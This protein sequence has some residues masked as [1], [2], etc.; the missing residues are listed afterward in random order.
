MIVVAEEHVK[1]TMVHGAA[2]LQRYSWTRR[3]DSVSSTASGSA[4]ALDQSRSH[5]TFAVA[6][7]KKSRHCGLIGLLMRLRASPSLQRAYPS[8]PPGT[9]HISPYPA[10]PT[11]IHPPFPRS[12]PS[13]KPKPI[14]SYSHENAAVTLQ[15]LQRSIECWDLPQG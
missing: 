12:P 4:S 6:Y 15:S 8:L 11:S 14:V 13:T 10:E 7:I 2:H 5:E 3:S 9:Q 1:W